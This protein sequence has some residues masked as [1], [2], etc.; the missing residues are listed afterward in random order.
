[1]KFSSLVQRISGESVDSWDVHYDGLAR[2]E[3]GEDIIVLS[4]GQETDEYTDDVIVDSAINSLRKGR[5]H[6]TQ[7]QGSMDLRL[8][9]AK[10]HN[11]LTNQGV[12]VNNCA[13]FAGAQNALFS[14]AQ[15]VLEHGDEVILI[16]PY[17]TTYPATFT[18]SGA[19]LVSVSVKAE[20]NF[21]LDPD[22]IIAAITPKTKAIVLNSP[23]NPM[24][25]IYTIEQFKPLVAAC[26]K[27]NIWLINDEV[28]QEILS[29]KDRASP[30]SLPGADQVCITVSSLSKSHRMTGWRLGW[31]VGPINLMGNLYNL[32]MCMA[33]GLPEFILDA[34]VTAL[35]S[36]TATADKVRNNMDSRR[37]LFNQALA[38]V[39]G[40]GVF[41][42]A[43][44]M[45]VVLDVSALPVTSRQF[46]RELL[47]HYDVGVLP[48]DGFGK[49]V[50]D[51]VRVS[52]CVPNDKLA[53]A[54]E[55][56]IT[57]VSSLTNKDVKT[58]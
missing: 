16:E 41:S 1:M 3:A 34:A 56:I 35:Q 32:A 8:A 28:Y 18:A 19:T 40:L 4:V 54:C 27:N 11:E 43:G 26:V 23:N 5:H 46:A 6:Y 2:L 37:K 31:I 14:A 36:G 24:G 21:E 44:G 45:Y 15:C 20:N 17:Y 7:V 58:G 10:R 49:S 29:P 30:A 48:C 51:L 13:V 25:A 57:Y 52:L 53:V 22:D 12:D 42:A 33:Y 9:I 50:T 38:D 39:D 47:D 55:R